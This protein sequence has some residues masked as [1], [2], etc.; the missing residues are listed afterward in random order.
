MARR[1][2]P[3]VSPS[4]ISAPSKELSD[5]QCGRERDRHGKLH[6]HP[7]LDDILECFFEDGITA[8]QRGSQSNHTDSI[9]RLPQVEPDRRRRDCYEDDT[10]NLD[11]FEATFMVV[12]RSYLAAGCA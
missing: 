8:N 11:D 10:E 7:A 9:K 3:T 4:R 5:S 1:P 6:R 2:R 12:V